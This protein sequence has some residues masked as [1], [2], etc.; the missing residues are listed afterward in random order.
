[1]SVGVH[2]PHVDDQRVGASL[3]AIRTRRRLRQSDASAAAGIPRGVAIRIEA[4][5]LDRVRFGD[6]RRYA[7]SLG[8]RF[9][10]HVLWQADLDRM[11]NRGHARMHEAMS[12]WLAAVGGW[13]AIPEVSSRA[14]A[15]VGSST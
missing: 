14:G 8:A 6:I 12:H 9:D 13:L 3:R 10:G 7:A 1:M 2:A 4:G 5:R 15:S 11:L